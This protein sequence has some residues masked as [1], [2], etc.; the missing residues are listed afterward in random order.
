[1]EVTGVPSSATLDEPLE[2]QVTVSHHNVFDV[3]KIVS[4]VED[5]LAVNTLL[6]RPSAEKK[7]VG[8]FGYSHIAWPRSKTYTVRTTLRQMLTR[9][10]GQKR[11]PL[12]EKVKFDLQ[13]HGWLVR[14][15]ANQLAIFTGKPTQSLKTFERGLE[16][17]IQ[18]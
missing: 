5:P 15:S 2:F 9:P 13:A 12:P 14:T 16:I 17:A 3:S 18:G 7:S 6:E 1:M 10:P 11:R 4:R 8:F